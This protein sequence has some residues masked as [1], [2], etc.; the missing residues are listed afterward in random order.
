MIY[1]L[2]KIL[3]PE[4]GKATKVHDWRNHVPDHIKNN[5]SV[6]SLESKMIAYFMAEYA[7]EQEHWS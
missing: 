4:W 3:V 1:E 7:S 6:I 5:W 2:E